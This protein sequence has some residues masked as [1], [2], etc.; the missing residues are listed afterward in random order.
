MDGVRVGLDFMVRLGTMVLLGL[1]EGVLLTGTDV[2]SGA[3]AW[4]AINTNVIRIMTNST[5][6]H[7]FNFII[8][9]A[10]RSFSPLDYDFTGNVEINLS[11][12]LP[13]F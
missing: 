10:E 4:Q 5:T 6:N 8:S 7:D 9:R 12:D 2:G 1:G 13:G 3:A 11:Q